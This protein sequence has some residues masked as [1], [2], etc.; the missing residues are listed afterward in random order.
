MF[1]AKRAVLTELKA[2]WSGFLVLAACII[3]SLAL[4]TGQYDIDSHEKDL[5]S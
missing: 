5:L 1:S 4:T 3:A 2:V